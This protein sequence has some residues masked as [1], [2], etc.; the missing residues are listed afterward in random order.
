MEGLSQNIESRQKWFDENVLRRFTQT[1]A[2]CVIEGQRHAVQ[3]VD[4]A[5]NETNE[6][7]RSL[8]DLMRPQ[9]YEVKNGKGT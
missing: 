7:V 5:R 4:T 1:G 9:F 8:Y 2:E 3:L 6:L